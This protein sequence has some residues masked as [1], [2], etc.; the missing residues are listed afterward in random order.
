[1]CLYCFVVLVVLFP[2]YHQVLSLS[3]IMFERRWE[4]SNLQS[5]YFTVKYMGL[6][7]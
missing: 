4:V 5:C 3:E 6:F 1:M 7:L 2:P